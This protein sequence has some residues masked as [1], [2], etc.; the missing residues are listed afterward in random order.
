MHGHDRCSTRML[1]HGAQLL[2]SSWARAIRCGSMMRSGPPCT[3]VWHS[4]LDRSV[5]YSIRRNTPPF[6]SCV[7]PRDVIGSV[8]ALCGGHQHLG[9]GGFPERRSRWDGHATSAPV[10]AE[11]MP[12][13]PAGACLDASSSTGTRWLFQF[14]RNGRTHA[15]TVVV[16]RRRSCAGVGRNYNFVIASVQ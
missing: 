2:V 3:C 11:A 15:R 12:G 14:Q 16:R 10:V 13:G 5:H 7:D 8:S 4:P 6:R 1:A 9:A